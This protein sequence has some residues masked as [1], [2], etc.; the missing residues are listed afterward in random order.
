[1]RYPHTVT[2]QRATDGAND[3]RGVAVQTWA[4]LADV[5]AFVQP[6]STRELM[7]LSQSGPVTSMHAAY[8]P[9]STDVT[10]ADRLVLGS[11]TYQIT[12][13]RDEAGLQHHL[14]VD[15]RLVEDA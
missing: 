7:Q 3:D 1:M 8:L 12:G 15:L 10:E 2:V 13:I 14:K 6:K 9:P 5:P 11:D 4:D